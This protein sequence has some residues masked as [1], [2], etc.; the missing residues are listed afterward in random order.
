MSEFKHWL[1]Q[2][3]RRTDEEPPIPSP[4]S[5]MLELDH[6]EPGRTI[7]HV[8]RDGP[9]PIWDAET[10]V[11]P[12]P[13]RRDVDVSR[14][15]GQGGPV[16]KLLGPR[17][18]QRPGQVEMAQI[19]EKALSG[20]H[21]ALVEAGTGSGKSFAYLVPLLW[22][23][24]R[25]FV[26]TANKTLQ[27]QLWEKD[28]PDLL[29]IA[30]R[31]TSV[32]LLKG[33]GNYI[34]LFKLRDLGKSP[35]LPGLGINLL[36]LHSMLERHP[37]GD[38]E[39]LRLSPEQ[40]N[41][42]T[43]SRYECL[44]RQCPL[45]GR[46]FFE[47]ARLIAEASD[48]VV[49]NHALLAHNMVL[50]HHVLSAREMV[51]IDEAQ[52]LTSYLVNALRIS[53]DYEAVPALIDNDI[54]ADNTQER[55][56]VAALQAS[57]EL[58]V[59]LQDTMEAGGNQRW[60]APLELPPA[61]SL[62]GYLNAIRQQLVDRYPPVPGSD[63]R[64]E[65]NAKHQRAIEAVAQMADELLLLGAQLPADQVRYCEMEARRKRYS[66]ITLHQ[67]P[68]EVAEYL[69]GGM[70]EPTRTVI[71][72]TATLTVAGRFDYFRQNAG[73]PGEGVAERKISSPFDFA[74][75]ALLYIP[76]GLVPV[77]DDSEDR[78]LEDLAREV[79]RLVRASRGRAFVLCT[80]RR[81]AEQLYELL[82]ERQPHPCYVQGQASR[83]ALLD[84]F[85]RDPGGAVLFGTKSFW[86]GVDIPGEALSLVIID[87]LPFAPH[88][89]PVIQRRDQRIRDAG[90]NPFTQ[91]MLPEAILALKQ[92]VGRLIR[93]ETDRGV[94][95]ILDSRINS[96]RYG[97]QVIA[98]LPPARRTRRFEDVE[99]FFAVGGSP[100][101]ERRKSGP[102]E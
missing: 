76:D 102:A 11:A 82:T 99:S 33:R 23:G 22:G 6:Y 100:T 5:A 78:Y 65:A 38:V 83:E 71:C 37:S 88:R 75:Q 70:W 10:Q 62:A 28:I 49:I 44:G 101:G 25:A 24:G 94:M 96:K 9:G 16:A 74:R 84:D 19:V 15:F 43:V 79:E 77:Y 3:L 17:Y 42:L 1:N 7:A 90:G 59:A 91:M 46:C 86:Q 40:R 95:A 98:S 14:V 66:A 81:R 48:L 26:S 30:P 53:V 61:Q 68:L 27:N 69:Q 13:T 80:S 64:D 56:R 8:L 47:K 50:G 60:A 67:Q 51:V 93:S 57:H 35:K 12:T 54:V 85:R 45:I 41:E 36:D 20:Q 39:T 55:H 58:F 63:D 29:S 73:V 92:G 32:A 4:A 89:D 34:C 52:E 18:R 31:E 97:A 87:K 21:H 72:T 2:H